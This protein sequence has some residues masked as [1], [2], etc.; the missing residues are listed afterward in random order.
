MEQILIIIL[1]IFVGLFAIR[2]FSG[3]VRLALRLLGVLFPA[4]IALFVIY[5]LFG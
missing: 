1:A 3:V 4:L 5:L 2:I